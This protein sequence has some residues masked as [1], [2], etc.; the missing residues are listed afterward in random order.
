MQ[1]ERQRKRARAFANGDDGGRDGEADYGCNDYWLPRGGHKIAWGTCH[2]TSGWGDGLRHALTALEPTT[3]RRLL[4]TLCVL[5][6]AAPAHAAL[7][8]P[9]IG[10]RW[11]GE[12]FRMASLSPG[13]EAGACTMTLDIVRC[14]ETWC[15]IEVTNANTCGM[16][17]LTFRSLGE[18]KRSGVSFEGELL[19]AAATEP[20]VISGFVETPLEGKGPAQL[21]M[22][23]DT[24]GEF[25][26]WRRSFPFHATLARVG[27]AVCSG[28]RPVSDALCACNWVW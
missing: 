1:I 7:D 16:T 22:T 14:G 21:H 5:A 15:G 8:A 28:E 4:L 10:G 9:D 20:Y 3:M 11:Q 26:I 19:L 12:N 27:D 18:A 6:A 25:R 13:C 17:A 23:G 2:G 24:G